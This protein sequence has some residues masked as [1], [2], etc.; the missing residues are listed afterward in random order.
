MNTEVDLHHPYIQQLDAIEEKDVVVIDNVTALPSYVEAVISPH[1]LIVACHRGYVITKEMPD[2]TFMAHDVAIL[3]P[4]QIVMAQKASDDY[5]ATI[6]YISRNFSAQLSQK[7]IFPRYQTRFRR[8]PATHLTDEQFSSVLDAISLIRTISKSQSAYRKEMLGNLVCILLNLVGEYHVAN[9]PDQAMPSGHELIFNR[10]CE[11]LVKHHCESHEMAFYARICCLSPKHF[12]E[13]I[14]LE[15]G[16]SAN[17]WI[18]TYITIRAKDM[19]NSHKEYTIQQI[20]QKLGF[21]EQ[22]AFARFFKKHTGMTPLEY[23]KR[24]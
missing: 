10:F 22:S 5:L 2:D 19:L 13:V 6:V 4:D 7:D 15:S 16:L 18:S 12:S 21:S 9:Y 20:S 24:G 3:P 14:K 11:A 8:K 1:M 17:E 23:R